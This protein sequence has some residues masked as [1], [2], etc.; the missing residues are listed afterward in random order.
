M[1]L[2][3]DIHSVVNKAKVYGRKGDKVTVISTHGHLS[4]VEGPD[5]RRF[6]VERV[7]L[8]EVKH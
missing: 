6:T 5:E 7:Y 2:A 8:S 1:Y 3:K 4:I